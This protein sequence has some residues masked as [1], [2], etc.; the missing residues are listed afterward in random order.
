[1]AKAIV[2]V[3]ADVKAKIAFYEAEANSHGVSAKKARNRLKLWKKML[4]EL[5]DC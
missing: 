4:N 3:T 5:T 2:D 1:M